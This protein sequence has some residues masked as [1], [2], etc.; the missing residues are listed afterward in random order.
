MYHTH[1][2]FNRIYILVTAEYGHYQLRLYVYETRSQNCEKR[3]LA[4]SYLSVRPSVR[5]SVCPHEIIRF[6]LDRFLWNLLL[7]I[8]RKTVEKIQVSSEWKKNKGYFKRIPIYIFDHIHTHFLL[9]WEM[10][11]TKFVQKI[12]THILF[13]IFFFDNLVV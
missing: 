11:Q 3:L 8:F 1:T 7:S 12:R 5:P 10:C 6:P 13:S 4:S 2:R 9:E